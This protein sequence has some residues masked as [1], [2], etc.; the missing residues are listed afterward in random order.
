MPGTGAGGNQH[1][2]G[3]PI[4]VAR[5]R[6]ESGHARRLTTMNAGKTS[7]TFSPRAPANRA[8]ETATGFG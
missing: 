3:V 7:T 1:N 4:M 5:V 6:L 8:F 2:T